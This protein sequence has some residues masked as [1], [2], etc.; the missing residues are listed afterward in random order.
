[1]QQKDA[2]CADLPVIQGRVGLYEV[3]SMSNELAELIQ[4]NPSESI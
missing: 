2:R 3:L 4:K 1:M